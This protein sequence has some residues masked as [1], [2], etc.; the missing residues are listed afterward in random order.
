MK[1]Y[2]LTTYHDTYYIQ[3]ISTRIVRI[4]LLIR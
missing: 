4:R 1:N 3:E 2:T